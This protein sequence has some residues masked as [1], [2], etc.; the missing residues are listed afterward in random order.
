MSDSTNAPL[1]VRAGEAA[2]R[3]GVSKSTLERWRRDGL[4]PA[5]KVGGTVL[6]RVCDLERFLAQR[7]EGGAE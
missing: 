7:V 5:A 6:F 4:I 2:R 3:L 1:A